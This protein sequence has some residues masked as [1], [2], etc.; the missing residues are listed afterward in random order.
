MFRQDCVQIGDFSLGDK[1]WKDEACAI[2]S[3]FHLAE[4]LNGK[5]YSP[6]DVKRI[7][8]IMNK[9]GCLDD[10]LFVS[11]DACFSV[12]GIKTITRFETADYICMPGEY[13]I[14]RLQKP[15]YKHFVPGDGKGHY[16]W[17]SLGI[18]NQ[19]A[20]YKIIEKRVITVLKITSIDL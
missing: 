7:A 8:R 2:E 15:K 20:D 16:S 19:Q 12:L 10:D 14:I 4:Q 13:E 9:K 17:D 3:V 11:W 1:L 6:E 5:Y 18:R